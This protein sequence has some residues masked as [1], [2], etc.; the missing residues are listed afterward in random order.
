MRGQTSLGVIQKAIGRCQRGLSSGRSLNRPRLIVA[1]CRAARVTAML[2]TEHTFDS[3]SCERSSRER[4][5]RT[6]GHTTK[7]QPSQARYTCRSLAAWQGNAEADR[8]SDGSGCRGAQQSPHHGDLSPDA[9][10]RG[11]RQAP[12]LDLRV[13]EGYEACHR[14]VVGRLPTPRSESSSSCVLPP[15]PRWPYQGG[16]LRAPRAGAS[17]QPLPLNGPAGARRPQP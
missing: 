7:G 12:D 16:A 3:S 11:M 5:R 14:I 17:A 6:S 9:Y 13:P 8:P 2:A 15:W 4:A 10:V 1:S